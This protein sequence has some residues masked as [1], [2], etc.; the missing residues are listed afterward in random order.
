MDIPNLLILH[1]LSKTYGVPGLRLGYITGH[2]NVIQLL[3]E[4]RH[5]WAMNA[6][7]IEAGK[8]LLKKGK[9]AVDN[10]DEYLEETERFRTNLCDIEG[11]HVFE[12]KTNYMLCELETVKAS[13]LKFH[14]IHEHGMLIRD[15]SNFYGLSEYFFRVSTQDPEENDALVAAIREYLSK[16]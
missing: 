8:F 4:R 15:C 7:S 10:L 16:Q 6:L 9:P 5:P 13:A 11:L 2:P 14:L 3:R 12:T 1:S